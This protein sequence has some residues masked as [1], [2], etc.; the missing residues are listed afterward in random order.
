[1]VLGVEDKW[2][3]KFEG[4]YNTAPTWY[5]DPTTPVFSSYVLIQNL[6]H[7]NNSFNQVFNITSPRSS[8]GFSGGSSG[9]GSGGG[10]GGSW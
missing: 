8:S 2:A 10:G 1:M 7:F 4:I 6:S 3:K 9:G 5:E